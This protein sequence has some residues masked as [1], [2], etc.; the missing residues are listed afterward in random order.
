[1]NG[2]CARQLVLSCLI[3]LCL[4]SV[5]AWAA[6]GAGETGESLYKT[7]CWQ[8]HGMQGNGMGINVRDMSVQPRD[9]TD[10][11]EMSTRSDADLFKAI[12]EGGQAISKSVLMPPWSGVLSDDEIH[13]LV[14]YLRK[15]C[16]CRQGEG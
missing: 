7:Y 3:G 6:G 2:R 11:K 8:C 12:K 1:M 10:A 16:R 14:R 13:R 5:S 9:H 4:L 15:L